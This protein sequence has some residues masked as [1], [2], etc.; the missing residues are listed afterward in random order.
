MNI[1]T[2]HVQNPEEIHHYLNAEHDTLTQ[3][4]TATHSPVGRVFAMKTLGKHLWR[5]NI[6]DIKA[7]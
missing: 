2:E 7:T 4:E 3:T 6:K 5:T 1:E